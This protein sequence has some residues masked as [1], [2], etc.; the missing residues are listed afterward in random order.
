MKI[1]LLF[2]AMLSS[3]GI[4]ISCGSEKN[5]EQQKQRQSQSESS[6]KVIRYTDLDLQE[7][8]LNHVTNYGPI[9]GRV[10][11]ANSVQLAAEVQGRLQAGA[12]SFKA[13]TS[14]KKG[15]VLLRIES[16]EYSYN[17]EAQKSAFLNTLTA[18]MP[19]LKAD[20]P[21]NYEAWLAYVSS[22][23]SGQVLPPL[24]E[25][26][27]DSEKFFITSRQ[28]YNSY[29][30][31]KSQE[32]R[33]KK[34]VIRAP[35]NG[36]L[37]STLADIGGL[38]SPGQTLGTFISAD[39][40]EI[41]AAVG[42]KTASALQIGQE[43]PFSN[44]ENDEVYK[45]TV[46]RINAVV[47]NSTQ[48]IPIFLKVKGSNIKSGSYLQG[49]LEADTYEKAFTIPTDI[50]ARDNTV[51]IL[52]DSVIAKRKLEV[53]ANFPDSLIVRGFSQGDQLIL[54]KFENPVSGLKISK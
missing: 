44:T 52:Q 27:S 3:T 39:D 45:A 41:E 43:I 14:F 34:Y 46:V 36:V 26:Q 10:I 33:L 12:R 54:N 6:V 30:S 28:V 51:L 9:T 22:Y 2:L 15:E 50:L 49:K 32:E 24:P 1:K 35:F 21:D 38:V 23:H 17:L 16:R 48:N 25:T 29:Y 42:F 7:V 31:I 18:M 53:L 37:T 19:D 47:D 20:Y 8:N 4:F 11:P 13:G 5:S 40:F